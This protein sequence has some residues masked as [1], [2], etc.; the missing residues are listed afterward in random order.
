MKGEGGGPEGC[1]EEDEGKGRKKDRVEC[2]VGPRRGSVWRERGW[3]MTPVVDSRD[4]EE[5]S[6]RRRRSNS[7]LA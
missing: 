5:D 4:V 2:L 1:V 6:C 7:C 3:W